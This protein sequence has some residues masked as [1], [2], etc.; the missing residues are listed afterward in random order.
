M[1]TQSHQLINLEYTCIFIYVH[2]AKLNYII[3]LNNAGFK[4]LNLKD[5]TRY[6]KIVMLSFYYDFVAFYQLLIF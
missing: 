1:Q 3:V 4:R 5:G 6:S 2:L